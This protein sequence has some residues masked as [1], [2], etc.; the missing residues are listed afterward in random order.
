MCGLSTPAKDR[1]A[2]EGTRS[3]WTF[4]AIFVEGDLHPRAGGPAMSPSIVSFL[5]EWAVLADTP[6]GWEPI[7]PLERFLNL[8]GLFAILAMLLGLA[9]SRVRRRR[10]VGKG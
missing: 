2:R 4:Q 6:P 3:T 7:S 5:A 9:C 10:G 8:A 1:L